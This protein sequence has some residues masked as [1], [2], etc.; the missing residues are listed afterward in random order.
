MQCWRDKTLQIGHEEFKIGPKK[1]HLAKLRKITNEHR[2]GTLQRNTALAV[3]QGLV[4][5]GVVV[6]ESGLSSALYCTREQ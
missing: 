2:D 5:G 1:T 6:D 4:A 3:H